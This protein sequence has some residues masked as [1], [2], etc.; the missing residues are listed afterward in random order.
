MSLPYYSHP[1]LSFG[2]NASI[3]STSICITHNAFASSYALAW[4]LTTLDNS[5]KEKQVRL[6]KTVHLRRHLAQPVVNRRSNRPLLRD[7]S[8]HLEE[9]RTGISKTLNHI[10]CC[11]QSSG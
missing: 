4:S 8:V 3:F 6:R 1:L 9:G 11:I 10:S 5:G 2:E 7:H